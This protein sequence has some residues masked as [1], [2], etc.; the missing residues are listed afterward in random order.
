MALNKQILKRLAKV[1]DHY[2]IE[3]RFSTKPMD[4][5]DT[6]PSLKLGVDVKLA[7]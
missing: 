6:S 5:G 4:M 1:I 3:T 2:R 7:A